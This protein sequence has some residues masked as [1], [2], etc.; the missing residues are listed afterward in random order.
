MLSPHIHRYI[1]L[2][3]LCSLSL[4][5]SIGEVPTSF[6]EIVLFANWLFE[7]KFKQKWHHIKTNRT[8]WLLCS[9]FILHLIGLTYTSDLKRGLDDVRVKI[10]LMLLPLVFFTSPT[11]TK[12]ELNILFYI[13]IT[14]ILISCGW[15]LIYYYLHPGMDLRAASR[16]ISH[17]RLGLLI[18]TGLCVLVWLFT[19][20]ESLNYRIIFVATMAFLLFAIVKLSLITALVILIIITILYI[21]FFGLKQKPLI[22]M[23]CIF[24]VLILIAAVLFYI[25]KEW[26]DYSYIETSPANVSKMVSP[27]GRPYFPVKDNRHTENG[28]YI[29]YNI[30]YEE[31]A[32]E[33]RKRSKVPLYD[34]KASEDHLAWTLIRYMSSKG[35]PKDSAGLAALNEDDIKNIEQGITN[36]KYVHASELSKRLKQF[37][38]EYQDYLYNSNPSGNTMLMRFE[39]WKA[40]LYIIERNITFG[41]GTGDAQKAFERAYMRTNSSLA[42]EWRLRSHNQFLAITVAFGLTGIILFFVY[43][44]YPYIKLRKFLH[45]VYSAFFLIALLSFITEDTLETQTGVTFFTYFNS[46]FLWLAYYKSKEN[47]GV[48]DQNL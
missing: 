30:Q 21:L 10:P 38:W 25:Q 14:G 47:E 29:A 41:V 40:A 6:V 34:N 33:W 26:K 39:F 18:D 44:F 37:F 24:G 42:Y 5:I 8:L 7:G 11:I 35:L 23:S 32:R 1:F 22:K 27:S 16:Y 4:A 28:F 13:F 45:P 9:L 48:P 17:I 43:L 46:L 36:Y 3:G 31:L 15:S 20:T 2:F 19:T 12:K